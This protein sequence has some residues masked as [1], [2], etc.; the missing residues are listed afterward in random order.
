M[1]ILVIEDDERSRELLSALLER[2]GYAVSAEADGRRGHDRALA[3]R[4]DLILCDIELPGMDGFAV[5]RSLR[6]A[7]LAIPIL[8]LTAHTAPD[9]RL[10]G[11]Q[12]G[13]SSYL[14]K[15]IRASA[16][17]EA[18]LAAGAPAVGGV[19]P[20]AP[21][22]PG[23]IR[24]E[25]LLAPIPAAPIAPAAPVVAR[26]EAVAARPRPRGVLAGL[27][28]IAMGVPFIL[29]P[30]GVPNAPSYLFLAMGIAFLISYLR[31]R[32]YVYL[33][34]MVTFTSFGVALL[35]PTWV[36]LRPGAEAP[37]F[38]ALVA[39]GLAGAFV[40]AP[41]RR[42]PLVPATI[43][44]VVAGAQLLTGVSIVP[45]ALQPYFVP[46]ILVGVGGYLLVERQS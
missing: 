35:L 22:A 24:P 5:V 9:D 38:V 11:E 46:L 21:V 2:D 32:Q 26:K 18:L 43:L 8:A 37:A 42:W 27:V 31:G 34:P 28:V 41:D 4:F 39:L 17:R 19:S 16:L 3:E 14:S 36:A 45:A 20:L 33:I 10:V 23:A 13:F 25:R 1:R 29:Q 44:G 12:S 15:P 30:L 6:G 40:L 7:G